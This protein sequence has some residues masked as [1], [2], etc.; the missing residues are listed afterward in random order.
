M[1]RAWQIS[2]DAAFVVSSLDR[3]VVVDVSKSDAHP[4]ALLGSGATIWR[5]LCGA[6]PSQRPLVPE[7]ELIEAVAAGYGSE[8]DQVADEIRAFLRELAAEGLVS[9]HDSDQYAPYFS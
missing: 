7:P 2:D 8:T 6:A 3:V 5:G 9:R 1:P 4:R